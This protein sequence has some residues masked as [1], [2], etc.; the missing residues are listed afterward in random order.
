[1]NTIDSLF[2]TLTTLQAK[3]KLPPVEMWQPDH[4]GAIDIAI[5][6]N[7]EWFHEGT[8]IQRQALTD[9]FATILRR[10][11]DAYYLVTP[12]EKMA[13]QVADVPFIATDLDVRGNDKATE[14]LFTTN[15]GDY[16]M[17]GPDN[18]IVMRGERPYLNVRN[19]LEARL[20]RNV[21]YRL[22]DYGIEEAD[23]LYVYSQGQP[24]D[25]GLL[26]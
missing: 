17:A 13:I 18:Q 1:M 24:F 6:N 4:T 7:G 2:N 26:R 20:T 10:E 19:G 9:L 23:H 3:K 21:Y 5:N 12:A 14:L 8:K 16:V 11:G 15:V 25:L 22:I